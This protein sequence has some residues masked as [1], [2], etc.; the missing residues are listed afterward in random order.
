MI[1]HQKGGSPPFRVI[2]RVVE[3]E[4]APRPQPAPRPESPQP[5]PSGIHETDDDITQE[6]W[7]SIIDANVGTM[8]RDNADN[9]ELKD[10]LAAAVTGFTA[11]VDKFTATATL[12]YDYK[13][14]Y[15]ECRK[16]LKRKREDCVLAEAEITREKKRCKEALDAN[17]ILTRSLETQQVESHEYRYQRD[18]AEAGVVQLTAELAKAKSKGYKQRKYVAALKATLGDKDATIAR[19]EEELR[20]TRTRLHQFTRIQCPRGQRP[21][22]SSWVDEVSTDEEET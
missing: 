6:R 10:S 5:G 21:G 14:A 16:A 9:D 12:A 3:E 17:Q 1:H 19:L 7:F 22:S 11:L 8:A 2:D 18:E 13:E 20:Q 15:R 4:P